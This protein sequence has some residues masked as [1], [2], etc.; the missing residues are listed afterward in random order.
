M[1]RN[2][3]DAGFEQPWAS[4]GSARCA[5]A[6]HCEASGLQLGGDSIPVPGFSTAASLMCSLLH[7]LFSRELWYKLVEAGTFRR[8]SFAI[9]SWGCG[10]GEKHVSLAL[11]QCRHVTFVADTD[12]VLNNALTAL[13][14]DRRLELRLSVLGAARRAHELPSDQ[15]VRHLVH[16]RQGS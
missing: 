5:G 8:L 4:Q 3:A 13:D 15:G 14:L 16:W 9:V 12:N 10:R 11:L 1:G 2:V 6:A 7:S